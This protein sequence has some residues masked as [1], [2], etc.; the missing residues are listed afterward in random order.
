MSNG[1][2][3]NVNDDI[4]TSDMEYDPNWS[5][6]VKAEYN[7]KRL[8]EVIK[9]KDRRLIDNGFHIVK[10]QDMKYIKIEYDKLV[11]DIKAH[12]KYFVI[13]G[14]PEI[15]ISNNERNTI[16]EFIARCYVQKFD[17]FVKAFNY[18][19]ILNK[20]SDFNTVNDTIEDMKS[21]GLITIYDISKRYI[22]S[23]NQD[24]IATYMDQILKYR[25]D[26][27]MVTIFT[28]TN[29]LDANNIINRYG[30]YLATISNPKTYLNKNCAIKRITIQD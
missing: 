9:T 30:G 29:E 27:K 20:L 15:Y 23:Y 16:S 11:E 8:L 18:S 19:D 6:A 14:G 12:N 4:V 25:F 7:K 3:V 24:T 13:D 26:N 2:V 1:A 17:Y 5:E 22:A 21:T 28:F 10:P